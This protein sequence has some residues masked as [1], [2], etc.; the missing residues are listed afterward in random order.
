MKRFFRDGV[1]SPG[2]ILED[3]K[4]LGILPVFNDGMEGVF[5]L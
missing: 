5:A 4:R 3:F 1:A 2:Q